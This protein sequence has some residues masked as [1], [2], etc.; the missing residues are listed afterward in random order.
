M[1]YID[2]YKDVDITKNIIDKLHK[3]FKN[4]VNIMEVCGTHTMSIYKNGIDKLLPDNINLISGPGCPVCVTEQS[5]ID[6]AIDLARNNDVIVCSFG[7]MLRV[8]GSYSS[9]NYEKSNGA[10]IKMVYSPLD[11]LDIAKDNK[12]KEVVFLGVGFETT[13]PI[14]GLAIKNAFDQNINNFSVLTSLKTMPKAMKKLILDEEVNINGFLCPGNVGSII[15]NDVFDILAKDHNIPMVISGFE[16]S[17]IV[18]SIYKLCQM[19]ENKEYRCE[20]IYKRIVKEDGNKKA[21][22]LI[23]EIFKVS[24][25]RWRGIGD[26]LDTGLEINE[27]YKNYDSTYKFNIQKT[28]NKEINK[29]LCGEI[30]KGKKRPTDCELFKTTCTPNTP[31]GACMVSSEGTCSNFY[32]YF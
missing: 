14:I 11:C 1:K 28:E 3:D 8:P 19:I 23:N 4:K 10:N 12:E 18:Y 30:M 32:K 29:C 9:L 25:G 15:G 20:N 26:I 21:Q 31:I 17:D 7:D 13:I 24:L 6:T 22:N 16:H 2:E 27:K 5:Y